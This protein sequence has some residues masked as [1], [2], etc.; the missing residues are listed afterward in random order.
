MMRTK[1]IEIDKKKNKVTK[2]EIKD[3]NL[4]ILSKKIE[5]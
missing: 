5:K 4:N 2:T 3:Y 1:K